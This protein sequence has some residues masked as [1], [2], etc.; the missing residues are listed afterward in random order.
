MKSS[1]ETPEPVA[2]CSEASD[3]IVRAAL[4]G[5]YG[6]LRSYLQRR[7]VGQAEADEVL[8][9]FMLRALE[10]SGD[11]RDAD[12]VRGWLSRVLATTIA[13][14]HRQSSK[15][16]I[17]EIPFPNELS[18]RLAADQDGTVDAA[19]C[20]CLYTHLSLLK[21]EHAEV[22]R[23]LDLAGEPREQVAA[24]LGVT[25]NNLTV[26][27][28]RARQALRE[29]LEQM[30]VVCLEDSFWECRCADNRGRTPP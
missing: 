14:H 10:R 11:I 5:S 20:E 27:L 12:S 8:Q 15:N 21:A 29:R 17:R 26:R 19:A 18:D 4:V 25:V 28:H 13:D 9:A 22:I 1:N 2:G 16:R 24:D 7:F 30:C 3:A 23:R 6:R